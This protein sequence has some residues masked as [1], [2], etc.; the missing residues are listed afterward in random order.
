MNCFHRLELRLT[1]DC[2][3]AA[4]ADASCVELT[5]D[6]QPLARALLKIQADTETNAE[7]LSQEYAAP[8]E[9]IRR[10]AYIYDLSKAG[11]SAQSLSGLFST[12]PSIEKRL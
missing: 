6:N 1:Y 9:D 7:T 8:H 3:N 4:M 10:A 2:Q 5:R 11:I 12:H